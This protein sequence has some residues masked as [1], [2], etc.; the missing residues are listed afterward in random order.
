MPPNSLSFVIAVKIIPIQSISNFL[1]NQLII[2][3]EQMNIL[4]HDS[5]KECSTNQKQKK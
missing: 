3:K 5:N 4:T 2:Q 1:N